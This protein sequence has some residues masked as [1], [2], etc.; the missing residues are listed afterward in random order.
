MSLEEGYNLT[1]IKEM[2]CLK[3]QIGWIRLP[4]IIELLYID[5][6]SLDNQSQNT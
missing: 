1:T 2:I 5:N 6:F 4:I 3:Y